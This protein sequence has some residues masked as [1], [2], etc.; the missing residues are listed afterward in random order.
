MT[1]TLENELIE[2]L[3]N[4]AMVMGKKK[5]QIIREA[6]KRYLP[7]IKKIKWKWSGKRIM[8]MQLQ[9]ITRGFK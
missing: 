1:I 2:E 5:A 7:L 4:T 3:S 9:Y 8:L 6:L